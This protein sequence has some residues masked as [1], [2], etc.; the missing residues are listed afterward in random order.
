MQSV[1]LNCWEDVD[2]GH[3]RIET[4]C[5]V[6]SDKID[7]LEQKAHWA[8]LGSVSMIEE[9]REINGKTGVD[10]R[11]FISSLPPDAEQIAKAVRAHWQVENNLHWTL[12][13]IFNEDQ[14]SV[15]KDHAPENMATVRHM[16]LSMLNTAGWE[17]ASLQRILQNSF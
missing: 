1:N 4:R 6:A 16:V 5:C 8:G 3:G 17:D 11:C 12:D 14:S 9:T 15:R 13:V 10:R 2:K 7:W